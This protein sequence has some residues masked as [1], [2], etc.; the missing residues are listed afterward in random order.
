MLFRSGVT[1]ARAVPR[2]HRRRRGGVSWTPT[3]TK[4]FLVH[5]NDHLE[6]L[7]LGATGSASVIGH[8]MGSQK[9]P[10][11]LSV[12]T[13]RASG[14]QPEVQ[15]LIRNRKL[16]KNRLVLVRCQR[17]NEGSH[18]CRFHSA[19]LLFNRSWVSISGMLPPVSHPQTVCP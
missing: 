11:N 10:V 8:L 1:R 2:W 3:S 15:H 16:P 4:R 14:T 7:R 18:A 6:M 9:T 13:G 12:H 5:I 19:I 17:S